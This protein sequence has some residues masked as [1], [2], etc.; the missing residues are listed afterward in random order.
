MTTLPSRIRSPTEAYRILEDDFS[1]HKRELINLQVEIGSRRRTAVIL[2]SAVLLAYAHVEGAAKAGLSVLLIR[3]NSSGLTWGG[4]SDRLAYFEIDHR[5][6]RQV[7]GSTRRPVICADETTTFLRSLADAPIRLEV[8]DLIRQIGV[9][10]APTV[11]KIL[12]ACEFDLSA[13]EASL[14][15]LDDRLVA[16][17]HEI[18][19]GSLVPV[20]QITA[21][22]AVSLALSLLDTMLKDFGNL[23][24]TQSYVL[25]RLRPDRKE[26]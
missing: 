22:T 3:L 4:V 16:R 14:G 17:R 11:R 25:S 10:N 1:Q 8:A 7:G 6:A 15:F 26:K 20:D 13:Y 21:D 23:L 19:H 24:V 12:A 18:A 2:R 5:I 9:V